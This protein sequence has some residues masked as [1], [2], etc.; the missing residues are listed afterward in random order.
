MGVSLIYYSVEGKDQV[1]DYADLNVAIETAK[2]TEV[3]LGKMYSDF[4]ILLTKSM[5]FDE[6]EGEIPFT[7]IF[8]NMV[9][10]EIYVDRGQINSFIP[11][12]EVKEIDHWIKQ[13]KLNTDI[14]FYTYFDS[15]E[16]ELKEELESWG[17]PNKEELFEIFKALVNMYDLA[18]KE[19]SAI[20]ICAG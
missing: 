18:A 10:S 17:T 15:L 2:N 7:L 13:N 16:E 1:T 19:G 12:T 9:T 20:V 8:G 6:Y 3:D 11:P 14:G 5:E 4:A